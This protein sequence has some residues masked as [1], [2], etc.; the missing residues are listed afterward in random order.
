MERNILC[1]K[2]E[3]STGE[4]KIFQVNRMSIVLVRKK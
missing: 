1:K 2:D 4:F 3:L